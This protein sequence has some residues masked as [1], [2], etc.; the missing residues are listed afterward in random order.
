MTPIEMALTKLLTTVSQTGLN[1]ATPKPVK[2]ENKQ[3]SFNK[4]EDENETIDEKEKVK[5]RTHERLKKFNKE[6]LDIAE[7]SLRQLITAQ[8]TSTRTLQIADTR[9]KRKRSKKKSKR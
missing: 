9:K 8:N 5:S 7:K 1:L 2:K 6:T 4:H 3:L